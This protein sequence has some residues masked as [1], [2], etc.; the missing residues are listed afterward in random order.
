MSLIGGTG[1]AH[2]KAR[3]WTA[4]RHV[5]HTAGLRRRRQ[6]LVNANFERSTLPT[7]GSEQVTTTGQEGLPV[8]VG[9]RPL[10]DSV[11][12]GLAARVRE[13]T[14]TMRTSTS[15]GR[16]PAAL[17]SLASILLDVVVS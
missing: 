4:N 3:G 16:P 8:D 13:P 7:L 14:T 9:R 2:P 11:R 6:G 5:H 15:S 10:V 1:Q 17:M 12:P